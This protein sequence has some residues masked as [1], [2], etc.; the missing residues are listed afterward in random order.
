MNL[1]SHSQ[2][3][4]QLG[5]SEITLSNWRVAKK[6]PAYIKVG[7]SVRYRQE[8]L[9]AWLLTQRVDP[10]AKKEPVLRVIRSEKIGARLRET[11]NLPPVPRG[12]QKKQANYQA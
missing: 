5:V 4:S 11:L 8:D 3:A 6:G 9:D 7:R 10:A 12:R 1:I 2:A